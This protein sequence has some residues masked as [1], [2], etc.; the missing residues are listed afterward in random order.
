VLTFWCVGVWGGGGADDV[1]ATV[2]VSAVAVQ[3]GQEAEVHRV[4]WQPWRLWWHGCPPPNPSLPTGLA[5]YLSHSPPPSLYLR[6]AAPGGC[7]G[8]AAPTKPLLFT[9][10][11][12]YLY[13]T[14]PLYLHTGPDLFPFRCWQ[15]PCLI[16]PAARANSAG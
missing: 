1:V 9:I 12:G 13:M 2:Q 7:G 16:K 5:S 14:P 3:Q 6:P 15:H 8:T 11:A 4:S 10:A